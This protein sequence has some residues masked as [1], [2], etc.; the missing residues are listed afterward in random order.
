MIKEFKTESNKIQLILKIIMYITIIYFILKVDI[1]Y[2]STSESANNVEVVY[3]KTDYISTILLTLC[4]GLFSFVGLKFDRTLN[5][6]IDKLDKL[7][8]KMGEIDNQFSELHGEHKVY[9][10][11]NKH[12]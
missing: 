10:S 7:T 2:G 1:I 9:T 8:E 6:T 5:I 11:G 4:G 3:D 12:K